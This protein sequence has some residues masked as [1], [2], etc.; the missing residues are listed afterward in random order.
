MY[1]IY[2]CAF[3]LSVILG[4]SVK[5]E[6]IIPPPDLSKYLEVSV[7]DARSV[8]GCGF[9]LQ[10]KNAVRYQPVNLPDSVAT[11]GK[12]IFI[13]FAVEKSSMT[14]CMGGRLIRISDIKVLKK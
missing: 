9:L 3:F 12:K 13:L 10:D 8:D 6:S 11:E 1:R 2:C 7:V 5:K 4:C 14:T